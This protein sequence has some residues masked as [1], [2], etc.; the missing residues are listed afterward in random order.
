MIC[1]M[2]VIRNR[3]QKS[4][5]SFDAICLQKGQF[6]EWNNGRIQETL[7][8]AKKHP[9][10]NK[11][12]SLIN[13][14]TDYTHGATHFYSTNI[15]APYWTKKMKQTAA[16]GAFKFYKE[17]N[18]ENFLN[19]AQ[20]DLNNKVGRCCKCNEPKTDLFKYMDTVFDKEYKLIC[21][22]CHYKEFNLTAL[23]QGK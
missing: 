20:I 11:A 6:V 3:S 21:P 9:K 12:A 15:P 10:F 23:E 22:L 4:G 18:M 7:N 17:Q 14:E 8:R 16:V 19:I 5:K 1:V 13:T 2:E